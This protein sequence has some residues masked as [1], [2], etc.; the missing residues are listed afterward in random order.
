MNADLF[1]AD[2]EIIY[3]TD[4]KGQPQLREK[5]VK[6][7]PGPDMSH[8][9]QKQRLLDPMAPWLHTLGITNAKGDVLAA[10]QDKWRQINKYLEIIES[11]LRAHP[12]PPNPEIADMGSGKGYLTFALFDFLK[13]NLGL[14]PHVVGIELRPKLVDFCNRTAQAHHMDGL[15]FKATDIKDYQPERL[16]MLI[17]LHACDTATDLALATGIHQNAGIIVA[18]PCC[19]K[20]IRRDMQTQN[21]LAP[22]LEHGILEERQAEILTDGIRA[23][24]LESEGYQT[25]VFEFISN[26]HTAKNVMITAIAGQRGVK[27]KQRAALD[28]VTALKTGFGITEHYLEK[29]LS[30]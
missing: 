25:K 11:L 10:S 20:Q 24:L 19:H 30:E 4:K 18:A 13:N 7:Q 8:D 1:A 14:A 27:A 3:S 6:R 21:E 29:L 12:L 2:R 26:D 15:E 22:V 16:D 5:A 17:A 28:K 23:L 9:R